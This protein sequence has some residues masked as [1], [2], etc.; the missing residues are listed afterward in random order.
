M[1]GTCNCETAQ[2][3][4][5]KSILDREDSLARAQK[6]KFGKCKGT[7]KALNSR[8]EIVGLGWGDLTEALSGRMDRTWQLVSVGKGR[9]EERVQEDSSVWFWVTE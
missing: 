2:R 4:V 3:R 9:R 6:G 5:G 7:M 1:W 8:A